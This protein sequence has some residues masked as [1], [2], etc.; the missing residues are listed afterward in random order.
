MLQFV[1]CAAVH[2]T[3][4]VTND[5]PKQF[6]SASLLTAWTVDGVVQEEAQVRVRHVRRLFF[7]GSGAA[8]VAHSFDSLNQT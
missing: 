1:R 7:K 3:R 2:P 4:V 8:V 6:L 5:L